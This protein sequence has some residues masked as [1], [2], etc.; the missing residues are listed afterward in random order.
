MERIVKAGHVL[1]Q[2]LF[3]KRERFETVFKRLRQFLVIGAGVRGIALQRRELFAH[4]PDTAFEGGKNKRWRQR[5]ERALDAPRRCNAVNCRTAE[6]IRLDCLVAGILP[7][8]IPVQIDAS[9][10]PQVAGRAQSN[11]IVLR[12][13]IGN[14]PVRR[15]KARVRRKIEKRKS[16]LRVNARNIRRRVRDKSKLICAGR[17]RIPACCP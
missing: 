2:N 17:D 11:S 13:R 14:K 12:V 6:R 15:T 3:K 7:V 10:R 1:S 5:K 16:A 4:F 8:D 9:S